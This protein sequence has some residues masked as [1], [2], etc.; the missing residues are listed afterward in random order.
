[1]VMKLTIQEFYNK[2]SSD[3]LRNGLRYYNGKRLLPTVISPNIFKGEIDGNYDDYDYEV[4]FD[5]DGNIT[6]AECS[7]PSYSENKFCKHLVAVM[8]LREAYIREE[9]IIYDNYHYPIVIPFAKNLSAINDVLKH[10]NT[11]DITTDS[12]RGDVMQLYYTLSNLNLNDYEWEKVIDG[13][14]SYFQNHL[15]HSDILVEIFVALKQDETKECFLKQVLQKKVL[16]E[17]FFKE[18]TPQNTNADDVIT[19]FLIDHRSLFYII[20]NTW[21]KRILERKTTYNSHFESLIGAS[22]FKDDPWLLKYVMGFIG[23]KAPLSILDEHK[24]VE[25]VK[26]NLKTN[27]YYSFFLPSID[28]HSFTPLELA[29]IAPYITSEQL[30]HISEKRLYT[31]YSSYSK[32]AK[33]NISENFLNYFAHPD[34]FMVDTCS[35]DELY[36][37]K[38]TIFHKAA[39]TKASIRQFKKLTRKELALKKPLYKSYFEIA[40]IFKSNMDIPAIAEFAMDEKVKIAYFHYLDETAYEYCAAVLSQSGIESFEGFRYYDEKGAQ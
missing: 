33:Y 24:V 39:Y 16:I 26:A 30:K 40:E 22:I 3:K 1:M 28:K 14:L 29:L 20:P 38:D 37:L 4:D 27:E 18:I 12:Y 17:P 35:I 31:E 34:S 36:A 32:S 23:E 5:D 15:N 25:F 21:F 9:K 13:F 19:D 7:C 6:H 2:V 8:K 10:L 11:L